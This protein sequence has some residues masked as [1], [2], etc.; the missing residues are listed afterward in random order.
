MVSFVGGGGRTK[1]KRTQGDGVGV[2]GLTWEMKDTR[3]GSERWAS[4]CVAFL[5]RSTAAFGAPARR[6]WAGAGPRL[7]ASAAG[8]RAGV[9]S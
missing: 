7:S 9:P 5:G 2:G 1:T 4:G 3:D 8:L 6:N